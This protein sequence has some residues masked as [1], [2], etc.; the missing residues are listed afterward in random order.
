MASSGSL[1]SPK[2]QL[3]SVHPKP[4]KRRQTALFAGLAAGF[5]RVLKPGYNRTTEKGDSGYAR[6]LL[7]KSSD[8]RGL[9]AA[10]R[11]PLGLWNSKRQT[12]V[13]WN[14]AVSQTDSAAGLG[15]RE[16]APQW[17]SNHQPVRHQSEDPELKV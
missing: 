3:H 4:G 9:H 12:A 10:V 16:E 17:R 14:R 2:P 8:R 6:S 7:C 13:G 11:E 5:D 1:P 15:S